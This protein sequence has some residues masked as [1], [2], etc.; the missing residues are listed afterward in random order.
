MIIT[1][2]VQCVRIRCVA[3]VVVVGFYDTF[4]TFQV[5]SVASDIEREKSDKLSSEAL[6]SS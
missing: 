1:E 4:L 5:I 2:I 3:A 6:I